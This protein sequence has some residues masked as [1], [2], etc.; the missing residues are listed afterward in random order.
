MKNWI[1]KRVYFEPHSM[2]Y[3]MAQR[4][5]SFCKSNDVPIFKTTANN[6]ITNLPGDSEAAKFVQAKS[7]LVVGVKKTQKLE[8]CK[9]S[10]DYQFSLVT[11]CPGNCQY[12]Y[13]YSTQGKKPYVRVY[14]NIEETFKS[15]LQYIEN[16]SPNIVTFEAASSGDPLALEH[17]TG[18]VYEA[19]EFF[20]TL[21]KG[22]LRLVSKFDNVDSI[23]KC[24]H[25]GHTTFRFSINADYVISNFEHNTSSLAERIS[26]AK[27]VASAGYPLGFIVAPIM[28]FE[29]WQKQYSILFESLSRE[30]GQ[31]ISQPIAFELIQHRY[32]SVAKNV[33]LDRF[34]NT[35]LDMDDEKRQLKWGKYGRFKYVY[36]KDQA[37]K[38]R[39]HIE[40]EVLKNFPNGSIQYFT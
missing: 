19:I 27:K 2:D 32:T 5:Y 39:E 7:T 35:K 33:I 29:G 34:P 15:I 36:P 30:L 22:R 13:L 24:N 4:I 26:A 18:S 17:I 21:P 20:G 6:R 31:Y 28:V 10:A 9:P 25:Q 40:T 8:V 16:H 12:C 23:L 37:T 14:V 38:L 3:P 11:N 1:P